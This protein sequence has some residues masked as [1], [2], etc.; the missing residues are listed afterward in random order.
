VKDFWLA[1]EYK[2]IPEFLITVMTKWDQEILLFFCCGLRSFFC[3]WG[4]LPW[5]KLPTAKES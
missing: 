5:G 2:G 1:V 4:F 3:S